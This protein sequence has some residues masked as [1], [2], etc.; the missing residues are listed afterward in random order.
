MDDAV[1]TSMKEAFVF[2]NL[3]S[4]RVAYK[5]AAHLPVG[6]VHTSGELQLG[7]QSRGFCSSQSRFSVVATLG[8]FT[9]SMELC[10]LTKSRQKSVSSTHRRQSE[11]ELQHRGGDFR[12]ARVW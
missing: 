3:K 7:L 1:G 10:A 8:D 6:S 4:P 9:D 12:F 5:E 2:M 11:E